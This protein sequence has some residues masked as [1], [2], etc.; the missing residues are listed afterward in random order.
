VPH[1]V[2]C[3]REARRASHRCSRFARGNLKCDGMAC[4]AGITKTGRR[5]QITHASSMVDSN[6]RSV[7]G[8][9]R[10]GS[11]YCLLHAK[12]F[13]YH[14]AAPSGPV[15]LLL[16]DLETTGTSVG[17]CRIVE[18]AATQAFD[19]PGLPGACF[20]AVVRAPDEVLQSQEARAAGR[21]QFPTVSNPFQPFQ[22]PS[23]PLNP[24]Q[25][26]PTLSNHFKT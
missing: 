21:L 10:R 25:T 16:L 24:F 7:A 13:M 18:L 11:T 17:S 9:L 5:C 14:A 26:F 1:A 23:N 19:H 8:P 2:L 3:V 6:G 22:T 20:A 12:P 4:C 15:V